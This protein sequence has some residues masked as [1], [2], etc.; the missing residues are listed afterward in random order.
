MSVWPDTR[1]IAQLSISHLVEA[2]S[3][4][5]VVRGWAVLSVMLRK[6]VL[7]FKTKAC[8]AFGPPLILWQKPTECHVFFWLRSRSN[9]NCAVEVLWGNPV[10]KL[11]WH[12]GHCEA[13][14]NVSLSNFKFGLLSFLQ[15]HSFIRGPYYTLKCET[16]RSLPLKIMSAA[17]CLLVIQVD[18]DKRHAAKDLKLLNNS[19]TAHC[20]QILW[21]T[22][23][24]ELTFLQLHT[25]CNISVFAKSWVSYLK[26]RGS[27][28]WFLS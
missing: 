7:T 10:G 5:A 9:L 14:C 13:S 27:W 16:G 26:V 17:V 6:V 18:L 4:S 2:S 1:G 21:L 28:S 19:K 24:N 22:L 8:D 25:W 15:D 23:I 3:E 11:S 20:Y 12:C